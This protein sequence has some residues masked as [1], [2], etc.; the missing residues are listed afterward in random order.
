MCCKGMSSAEGVRKVAELGLSAMQVA[1]TH[2]IYMQLKEAKEVGKIAKEV[3]VELSVHTP[4]Y[5]NLAS[6]HKKI[7]EESKKRII[8]SLERGAA[9]G[10]TVVVTHAGYYGKDK[11]KS[12]EMVFETCK[13]I[14]E[15]IEKNGW[16]IDFGLETMGKQK[17]WG[18][19]EEIIDVCKRLKHLIPYL[20]AAHLYALHGGQVN[21]KDIFDKLEILKLNKIHSHFSG[22]KYSLVGIGRGNEKQHVPMKMAGPN[23]EDY[24]KEILKRKKD[25]TIISES[26][27]LEIDSLAMKETFEKL[28]YEF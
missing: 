10:A 27:I 24:A 21:F 5:V 23:F 1:F 16:N 11:I 12:T 28:G 7:I 6:E 9:M 26:P 14:T 15:H 18:T 20:D 19:L 8:D 2:S 17:S 3:D 13:E 4:Y 25:I 22:I